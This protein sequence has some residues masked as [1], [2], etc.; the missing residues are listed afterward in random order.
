M[1]ML[2]LYGHLF[3]SYTWKA[4]IALYANETKFEFRP[5]DGD[6]PENF[7]FVA[8]AHPAG[9]FPVLADGGVSGAEATA[10]IEY[11]AVH[12]PG[13][14]PLIPVEPALAAST[15]MLDR[16]FDNYV[17]AN[18]QRVVAA[19]FK[20][21]DN[22]GLG[23]RES[24]DATEFEAGEA[25]LRRTYAWLENWLTANL[26][27]PNVSLVTC[28]AAPSLFY[29]DWVERIP[30]DCPRLTTLRVELLAL[31]AVSRCV[32]DARP[33][34]AYFPPGAPDRD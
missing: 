3:S 34:R 8:G 19:Y 23:L 32:E 2:A 33:Y 25:A 4:L 31:P 28:A 27:P 13:E 15:R 22:P 5:L 10:I 7:E 14:A 18:M 24:P 29:A 12:H 1:V 17:M 16:V 6:H 11:L 20:D 26:L 9:K 21:R 30:D